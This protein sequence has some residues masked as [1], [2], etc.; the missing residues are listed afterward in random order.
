MIE[1]TE[2]IDDKNTNKFNTDYSQLSNL[3]LNMTEDQQSLLLKQAHQIIN[4]Y[5]KSA[6]LDVILNKNWNFTLGFLL[7]WGFTVLLLV[8][9]AIS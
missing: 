1:S 2:L 5:R 9:F 4:E 7:G 6:F 3:I 8:T